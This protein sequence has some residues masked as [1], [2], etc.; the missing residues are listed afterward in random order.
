MFQRVGVRLKRKFHEMRS[1]T[2]TLVTPV[3]VVTSGVGAGTGTR[4][5]EDDSGPQLKKRRLDAT[6]AAELERA[7]DAMELDEDVALMNDEPE[8]TGDAV[9]EDTTEE[10][11]D[12]FEHEPPSMAPEEEEPVEQPPVD[13][14]QESISFIEEDIIDVRSLSSDDDDDESSFD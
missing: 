6:A 14:Q 2:T 4:I 5:V 1:P 12:A 3:D 9:V 8:P 13:S 10:Q 7:V 11:V